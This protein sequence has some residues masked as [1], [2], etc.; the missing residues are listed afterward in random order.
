[1]RL[2][3]SFRV[4]LRIGVGAT[5]YTASLTKFVF[6]M[7][8]ALHLHDV[9]GLPVAHSL[10]VIYFVAVIEVAIGS[11]LLAGIAIRPS[12]MLA[13]L[14]A[15]GFVVVSLLSVS[16]PNGQYLPCGCGIPEFLRFGIPRELYYLLRSVL[17]LAAITFA[18]CPI[19]TACRFSHSGDD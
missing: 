15:V 13:T 11:T 16:L 4:L 12:L 14:L 6:P 2:L 9:L 5:F 10:A 7:H 3:E 19:V 17:F 18:A 8:P 1:M